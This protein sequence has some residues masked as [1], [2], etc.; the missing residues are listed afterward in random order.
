ML[1]VLLLG[2]GLLWRSFRPSAAIPTPNQEPIK[3]GVLFSLQ[4]PLSNTGGPSTD[5]ALLAIEELNKQ[6]GLLGRRVEA[7]VAD[8]ESDNRKFA[9]LAEK[10]IV[11]DR[12]CTIIGCRSSASRKTIRPIVEK[13]DHLLLYPMQFEGLEQSP[14]FVYL[15]TAPNQQIVPAL[16]YVL[17]IQRKRRL[18]LIGSDYVFPRTAHAIIRDEVQKY[19][20]VRIVGEKYIPFGDTD[21]SEA[22]KEIVA[23]KPDLILNTINGDTNAAFFRALLRAGIR[24]EQT[25]VLSFSIAEN[26]LRSLREEGVGHYAAWSY[27]QSIDRPENQKLLRMFRER[28]GPQRVLSD[29]METVYFGIHLWAQAVQS[30]GSIE[31]SAIRQ[32]MKGRTLEAPEGKVRIDADTGYTWRVV[33]MGRI[34]EG[35]QFEILWSSETPRQPVPFPPTRTRAAWETFLQNLYQRWGGSWEAPSP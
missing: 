6:G 27:F 21:V 31:P 7:V 34:V 3:I 2:G 12:V 5:M 32:A 26:D 4:G 11:E 35:G 24:A 13:H 9:Q 25:P 29:P 30:S 16:G 1:G 15:G 28:Y 14:N 17:G 18:F 10:L 8:G 22:I 20:E 19:P 23:S 33:R